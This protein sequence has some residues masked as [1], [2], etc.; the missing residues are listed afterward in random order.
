[1]EHYAAKRGEVHDGRWAE[2]KRKRNMRGTEKRG[3]QWTWAPAKPKTVPQTVRD[4][5]NA[6]GQELVET[7]LKPVHV[8]P[9]RQTPQWNYIVDIFTRW[10][11]PYFYFVAK[12]ACPGPNAISPFFEVGFARLEYLRNG[13][14]N[15]AY[16]RHTGQWWQIRSDV[17]MAKALQIVCS[18][19]ILH[20]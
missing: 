16:M 2:D 15:I 13:N 10:R 14:F 7:H 20:P 19:S 11:G 6:R 5:V 1:M 4:E 3:R 9:P 18:E 17:P 8:Q 12:Y